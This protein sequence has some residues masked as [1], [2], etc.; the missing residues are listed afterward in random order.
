MFF[1]ANSGSAKRRLALSSSTAVL[2]ML[3]SAPAFA[4]GS[5]ETTES[6]V[7]SSSRI[8]NS[9][10][11]APTPTTVINSADLEKQANTNV[12]TTVTQ[13]P[14]LM[15]STGSS[16]GNGGSSNGVNGLSALNIRGIGTNRNLILID[17][18]RVVPTSTQGVVDISQ[19]PSLLLQ[20][21]DVVTG[22]A[23]ASWGSD[24]VTGVVNFV[25]DKKFE[26]FKMNLN[27]AISTYADDPQAQIQVA[28]GT[29]FAG[30][31]GHIEVSGEFTSEAGVNSVVGPRRWYQNP[32]QIQQFTAAS[33]QPNGCTGGSPMWINGNNGKFTQFSYGGLITRG[34]LMGTNFGANGAAS[35]FD[36]GFG[37]NGQPAVPQRNAGN[38][39]VTGCANGYCFGGDTSGNQTGYAALVARLVRGNTF[40]RV[41]YDITP[42]IEIYATGMYSEVV[43]WD[44]PTQSF[45]KSD[46][47]QVACDNPFLPTGVAQGCLA[48]NGQTAAYNSQFTSI[49]QPAGGIGSTAALNAYAPSLTDIASG[50][51]GGFV[52][53][54]FSTGY[55]AGK[56]QYGTQNAILANVENYNNRTTRRFVVGADGVFNLFDTDW[57]FKAYGEHGEVDYHNTLENILVTPYY[58]AAIDAVQVTANNQ[59]AFPGVPL[60]SVI[61]RSVAAR[62]VGCVPL[63]II[64]TTGASPAARSFVQG[65]NQDGSNPGA[66]GRFPWQITHQ[67]QE[68]FDVGVSGAPFSTWAGK[69]DIATGFQY[70]EEALGTVTD[71]ASRGNCANENFG[72][73]NYG[74]GG[75]PLL[76]PAGVDP[77][78]GGF[79][80]PANPNWYAG[81]FQQARGVFH[82]WE[83][84]G[85]T[86]IPLLDDPA[87][88]HVNAN[89]AGRYTHYTT[90]GDVET[91]KVGATWDTPIDGLRVLALQ[92]RDVRAPNLAELFA[93]ARVNNGSV[94]DD[95]ALGGIP[96]QTIS[97]LPNP[98]T[99]NRN[100]KPEK[101]QTTEVG[102]R[103]SPSYVPGLNLS[104]TYYRVGVRGQITQLSQQQEM[105]LCF[106][107]NALQCSFISSAGGAWSTGGVI[108]AANTLQRPLTQTTP[109]VNIASVVTD[110]VDYEASYRFGLNDAIDWGMGGDVTLRLLATNVMKFVTNPG[111]IGGVITESAG[112]NNGNTPHW[113]IFFNQGYDQ[114]AWGIFVNE[115]WFSEGVI[116]RNWVSC[117]ANCPAPV[118]TNHPTVSSNYMPGELYFDVGGHYDVSAHSSLYFKVDNLTNQNPGNAIGYGPANQSPLINPALYDVLGRFYHVGI[119]ITD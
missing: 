15:G 116:N 9:G 1:D 41:S 45:F 119:R 34:P 98:I 10:F 91:W 42:E 68:V 50:P 89:L 49:V 107:G 110:G 60:G 96:N 25:F 14:S 47:L 18:E 28:G 94:V 61:C 16:V 113:K 7:V 5:A 57:S 104:A 74:P 73:V 40:A 115:R 109:Q 20:R 108:N 97:P 62:S 83:I 37:Y 64:G 4:Q 118:D 39:T 56:M 35:P 23:S 80:P 2:A 77:V 95:F 106:N 65:I 32:Q 117:A 24:A 105:D 53:N 33:C 44:K 6:V 19:F 69:V 48:N 22:G 8:M 84:F 12:F 26:G 101:G 82:E 3:I 72:G 99:A 38:S 55:T 114:D 13:L 85:E 29:S 21:V 11:E 102:L 52:S 75:N 71:C 66:N 100:L 78:T 27:G 103:W 79:L 87:W 86:N 30:G 51:Q 31:R 67:R 43:T 90:S 93:G 36:Y 59:S 112:T 63:N 70:R 88:G 46:N 81:N 17:G 54:G 58:N 111:F 76:N 92:S